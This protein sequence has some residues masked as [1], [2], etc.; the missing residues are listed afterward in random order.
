MA[1]TFKAFMK[2]REAA[3]TAYT[4]GDS[5]GVDALT[6]RSEPVTF[7]GPDGGSIKGAKAVLKSFDDGAAQFLPESEGELEIL[8]M[9]GDEKIGYWT[10]IQHA[11][12]KMR[13]K[14]KVIPMALRITETFRHEDGEWKLA[15]RHADMMKG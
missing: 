12:V 2:R 13:G 4:K 8:D 7:F 14:D 5:S 9:A 10:G 15:H 1:E 3:A 11:R 6:S